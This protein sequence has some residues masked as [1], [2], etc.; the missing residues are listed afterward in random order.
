VLSQGTTA[1]GALDAPV[2][3]EGAGNAIAVW[4]QGNGTGTFDIL[5]NRYDPC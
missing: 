1:I 4:S 5:A 3:F 2:A